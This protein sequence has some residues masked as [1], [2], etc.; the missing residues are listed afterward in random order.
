MVQEASNGQG[1]A[2]CL[3]ETSEVD[4]G[5]LWASHKDDL[6][7]LFFASRASVVATFSTYLRHAPALTFL[8]CAVSAKTLE[9]LATKREVVFS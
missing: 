7:T 2:G 4:V 5:T 6:G 8:P 9:W 1:A 3:K